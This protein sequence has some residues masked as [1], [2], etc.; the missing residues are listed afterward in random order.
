MLVYC[1]SSAISRGVHKSS[2][3]PGLWLALAALAGGENLNF[4]LIAINKLDI[5]KM[6]DTKYTDFK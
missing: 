5:A 2:F 4:Y 3:S 1:L 6:I